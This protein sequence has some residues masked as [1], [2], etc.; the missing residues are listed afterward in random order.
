[1]AD[2]VAAPSLDSKCACKLRQ[3]SRRL[4]SLDIFALSIG[5]TLDPPLVEAFF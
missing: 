4:H 2:L 3:Y 1:M 5:E